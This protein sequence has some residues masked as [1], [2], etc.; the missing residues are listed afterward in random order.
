MVCPPHASYHVLLKE[1]QISVCY[2]PFILKIN[3]NLFIM[4]YK[5]SHDLAVHCLLPAFSAPFTS[6]YTHWLLA[7]PGICQAC[8]C[9]R[10]FV[11]SIPQISTG[12][13]PL[14]HSALVS[15]SQRDIF[16]LNQSINTMYYI[17]LSIGFCLLNLQMAL[18]PCSCYRSHFQILSHWGTHVSLRK[19]A[20]F[21]PY[22]WII[23]GWG[24]GSSIFPS[25]GIK[26]A[27][28][29]A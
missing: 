12:P 23:K 6:L 28:I 29:S 18:I 22:H 2:L 17:K 9:F 4:D 3:F 7:S 10:A 14:F 20:E 11:L 5:V 13:F 15:L 27:I 8:S 25:A 16:F 21:S 1:V 26:R 19:G 24:M